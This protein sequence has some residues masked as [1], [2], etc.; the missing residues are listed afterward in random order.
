MTELRTER[1]WLRPLV[2]SDRAAVLDIVSRWDVVRNLA[3]WPYPADPQMVDDL[4][5][6][7]AAPPTG[8][9]GIDI[10]GRVIGLIGS[11][12]SMGFMLHPDFWGRGLMAEALM[13]VQEH[14][15]SDLGYEAMTGN[16]L[17]DNP[18]SARVFEKCGWREVNGHRCFSRARNETLQDRV[19]VLAKRYDWLDPIVTDRLILRPLGPQDFD[20]VWEIV[21][22]EGI[23][24]QLMSWPWPA[25]EDYTRSRLVNAQ[26]SAGLVSAIT[27]DGETLGMIGC[28]GGSLWYAL[29]RSAW[30]QGI[31]TEAARGK[32][33]RAFADPSVTRLI[34]GTWD[35]NPAS[36]K[37][38]TRLGFVQTGHDTIFHEARGED[39]SGP[40][41][42][43]T[44]DAWP[45]AH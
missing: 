42:E 34:A 4:I 20:A 38:L 37:I 6:R 29:R 18:G 8:G 2:T 3:R 16:V 39:A 30:G 9:F 33:A 24:R 36:A 22:D 23:V 28:T 31:A 7:H 13:A 43:L 15:M 35:D 5:S 40:D 45:G 26:A 19:F 12:T 32:I 14:G 27:R 21:S 44:R 10:G 41:F 17:I 1:L 25:D 11:G